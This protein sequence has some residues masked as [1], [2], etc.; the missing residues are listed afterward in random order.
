MFIQKMHLNSKYTRSITITSIFKHQD[1]AS[2]R[3]RKWIAL[4]LK[5]SILVYLIKKL[6]R[7][8]NFFCDFSTAVPRYQ[9]SFWNV[10]GSG[11]LLGKPIIGHTHHLFMAV[12]HWAQK[13]LPG[14]WWRRAGKEHRANCSP[15]RVLCLF[16]SIDGFRDFDFVFSKHTWGSE[17][18]NRAK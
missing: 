18:S 8:G 13:E 6:P 14:C 16:L 1:S 15:D 7:V 3:A 12:P 5:N 9:D 17:A 2:L 4:G 11:T 10:W